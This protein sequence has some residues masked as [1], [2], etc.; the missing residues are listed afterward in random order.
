VFSFESI[1]PVGLTSNGPRLGRFHTPHGVVRTPG[2]M[3]VGTKATVKS[4][5]PEEVRATGA[6][7]ILSNTFHLHLRP[8]ATLIRKLGGLHKFMNWPGPILTDSGGFQVFSL[9]DLRQLDENG[10]TFKSPLDGAV[11]EMTPELATRI[12]YD[13]GSDVIMAFD[14]CP[15]AE[16]DIE[17]ARGSSARTLRWLDR[18]LAE[19]EVRTRVDGPGGSGTPQTIFPIA[20]GGMHEALRVWSARETAQ[21][22]AVGYAV[23]GLAVGESRERTWPCLEASISELP[24][25][26]PRYLMGVGTPRDFVEAVHRGV[27]LFDCV[28]P[29]RNARNGQALT[30]EGKLV[31]KN[32][33]YAEDASPLSGACACPTCRNYSRAYLRHLFLAGEI[34]AA[35]LITFHNLWY[36]Q[37]LMAKLREAIAANRWPEFRAEILATWPASNSANSD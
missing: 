4:M 13:L 5:L 34:L 8:G 9:S 2:F 15:P 31:I 29:T 7:M 26:R 30:W 11:I 1:E 24:T 19:L 32:A 14:E 12:Q 3:P 35:R 18:C 28:L 17:Q 6:D 10:V 33:K 36:F 21:R 25:D 37:E 23:G 20:Q 22:P 27:D 16:Y